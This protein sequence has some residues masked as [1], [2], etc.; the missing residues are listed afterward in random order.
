MD[1][2]SSGRG[3]K[4]G[5]TIAAPATLPSAAA[6][7]RVQFGILALLGCLA[8]FF[9]PYW[10]RAAIVVVGLIVEMA[11]SSA[12]PFSF[13]FIV[14]D[15][16]VGKNH[17]LLITIIIALAVGALAVSVVGLLRD[18]LFARLASQILRDL[19]ASMFEQLQR[20]SI[21]FYG[22]TN[23]GDVLSRFS[24]DIVSVENALVSSIPWGVLPTLDVFA[25]TLLLFWLDWRLAL[26]SML[27]WPLC[28]L[29]PRFFAPRAVDASYARKQDEGGTLAVVQ[30]NIQSQPAVKVLNLQNEAM[31]IFGI[32]NSKLAESV[33]KVSF[34]SAMV[35]R[36]AGVSIMLL[37]VLVLAIGAWMTSVDLLSVGT[38]T[39]FQALFLNLSISLSYT[40]QYVPT[41]V[42]AAGGMERINELFA[43]VP[44][45]VDKPAAV[46]L[47]QLVR[48]VR[49]ESVSFGYDEAS[50]VLRD[51]NI[52]LRATESVA[53]VGASGSG[54][55]TVL[56]LLM[57]LYEPS[58]GRVTLDGVDL[59]DSTQAS[60]RAQMGVVFQESFLF[61]ASV[62]EN[63]RFGRLDATRDEIENAARAAEIHEVIA[64]LPEGYDSQ[65]GERGGRLSG[66]QRQRIAIARAILR[67]PRIL[68]LDEATSALDPGTESA[69]NATLARIGS[70]R[71]VVSV[72]H[73]LAAAV[74]ADRICVLD[75]GRLVE[76]GSHA[77]LLEHNG[78]YKRLWEKQSGF[79]LSP[80]GEQAIVAP[81]WLRRVKLFDQLDDR[82]L[83][84]LATLFA[85]ERHPEGRLIIHQGDQADRFYIIVRGAVE[86]LMTE[87]PGTER[88]VAVLEDG[89]HFG[90]IALLHSVPRTASV[91]T[92]MQST[93]LSLQRQQ[94]EL[95][96]EQ[97][98]ELRARID[99]VHC[100]RLI[101]SDT[102]NEM[103][104]SPA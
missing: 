19:R 21:D 30:E 55:S 88:R 17:S 51:L 58:A 91:R 41:L 43:V 11:F 102:N 77:E 81:E 86:V 48:G 16:L 79:Q 33:L 64:A 54:K 28:L 71:M 84:L 52:E 2:S 20:L 57:R 87:E 92:L 104:E 27:V 25:N 5:K 69:I 103:M 49:F 32:R 59:R 60:L 3:E 22:R 4:G 63:I 12:L 99:S 82:L 76:S 95:L 15:G 31:R 74:N 97:A 36:S 78:H 47:P 26:V 70:G 7:P 46:E 34:F 65:I 13:K 40:T 23:A 8:R 14:D 18:F 89:D 83:R 73:R 68:V 45:V 75:K 53:F 50:T 1:E 56:S 24:G 66:G 37:Q 9:R 72:T 94:F 29:G 85:T 10:R 62:A 42:Q 39:A 38:L 98:P 90:E 67:E 61:N 93:L 101:A 44:G 6:E 35:E 96:L 80:S 100:E